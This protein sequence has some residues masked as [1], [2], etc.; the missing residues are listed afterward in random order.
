[1]IAA[2]SSI[3]LLVVCLNPPL[4]SRRCSPYLSM[5]AYPPG[6]GV[7][8]AG[9]IGV[10]NYVDFRGHYLQA[11]ADG[12][13]LELESSIGKTTTEARNGFLYVICEFQIYDTI[14]IRRDD[15][16]RL[17]QYGDSLSSKSGHQHAHFQYDV[18]SG[19]GVRR[20]RA[21]GRCRIPY[22]PA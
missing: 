19:P 6:P 15:Y 4:I 2:V 17:L 22:H 14:C 9:A 10:K 21:L 11:F 16:F 5:A 20:S 1:M 8:C 18:L 13:R 7:S 12:G 3:L